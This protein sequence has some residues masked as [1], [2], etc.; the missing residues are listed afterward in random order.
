[1]RWATGG[2]SA[3]SKRPNDDGAIFGGP[4]IAPAGVSLTVEPGLGTVRGRA[5]RTAWMCRDVARRVMPAGRA[6]MCFYEKFAEIA[7]PIQLT[8]S[9][10][11]PCAVFVKLL[12]HTLHTQCY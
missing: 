1:M 2:A 11:V 5:K 9:S 8:G 4:G 12:S 3:L 7:L 10:I 6:C